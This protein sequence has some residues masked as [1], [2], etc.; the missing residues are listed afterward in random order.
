MP[1]QYRTSHSTI[2]SLSTRQ[3]H[4]LPNPNATTIVKSTPTQNRNTTKAYRQAIGNSRY[5]LITA[6]FYSHPLPSSLPPLSLLPSASSPQPPR[7]ASTRR[8]GR[9]REKEREGERERESRV[10]RVFY[11][12]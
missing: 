5:S 4:S 12:G 11:F 10:Q 3:P 9:R 6:T 7:S 2:R 1:G 8:E